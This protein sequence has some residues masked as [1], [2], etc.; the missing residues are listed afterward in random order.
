M[1]GFRKSA[2]Q[3]VAEILAPPIAEVDVN[4]SGAT[5]RA[6]LYYLRD[7]IGNGVKLT[8]RR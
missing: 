7:R 6:K 2:F 1:H 5:R 4:R 8:E 3:S